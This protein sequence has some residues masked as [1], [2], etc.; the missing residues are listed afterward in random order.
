MLLDDVDFLVKDNRNQANIK[1]LKQ[2]LLSGNLSHCYL[3]NGNYKDSLYKLALIFAA[4]IN[5]PEKGCGKCLVCRNTLKEIYVDLQVIEAEGIILRKDRIKELQNFM[6]MSSYLSGKKISIINGTEDMNKESANMVLKILEEP[7][8]KDSI[9][10]LLTENMA[11][12]LPTIVSRCMVFEWNFNPAGDGEGIDFSIL[13]E[14]LD[15]GIKKIIKSES[16]SSSKKDIKIPLNLTLE[17]IDV[18]KENYGDIKDSFKPE[19]D[20]MEDI[21]AS[22][23]F[24]ENY[25]KTL[26]KRNKRSINKFYNL[27][28]NKV[29]DIIAAWLEDIIVVSLGADGKSLNHEINFLFIKENIKEVKVEKV[30]KLIKLIENNRNYLKYSIYT[31]LALDNILVQFQSLV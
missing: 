28:I 2:A 12:V 19:M 9:F 27:G 20:R 26:Q 5:C 8:N 16:G 13:K 25:E 10:I 3:F 21:G 29:F 1:A 11:G 30:L 18:L 7:P 15:K 17:I 4:S 22:N 6:N 23:I 14:I 24:I 31:E